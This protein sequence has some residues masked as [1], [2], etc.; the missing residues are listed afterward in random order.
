MP[1]QTQVLIGTGR[2]A[3]NVY[4]IVPIGEEPWLG[5]QRGVF[6]GGP[7]EPDVYMDQE[8]AVGQLRALRM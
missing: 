7:E 2:D 8:I 5:T 3:G 4:S 1:L 6:K